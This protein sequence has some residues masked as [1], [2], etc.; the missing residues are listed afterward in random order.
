MALN[1]TVW[2]AAVASAVQAQGITAGTPIT[3]AQLTAIWQAICGAHDTHITNNAAVS[4]T[5]TTGAGAGG[6]VTGTVD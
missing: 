3:G 4:G 5:V 2:G 6:S 1:P